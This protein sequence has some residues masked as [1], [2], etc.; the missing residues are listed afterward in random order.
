MADFVEGPWVV[1]RSFDPGY[2]LTPMNLAFC[3]RCGVG[4]YG[5]GTL[6]GREYNFMDIHDEWHKAHDLPTDD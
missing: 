4:V 3:T 2:W 5:C 6:Q 1:P